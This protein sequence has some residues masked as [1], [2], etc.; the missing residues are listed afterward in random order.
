MVVGDG[1]DPED[2]RVP[3]WHFEW[4]VLALFHAAVMSHCLRHIFSH[5]KLCC[6]TILS[7]FHWVCVKEIVLVA[8]IGPPHQPCTPSRM[9]PFS[10]APG[11]E[12]GLPEGS[13]S[14]RFRSPR[15][16]SHGPSTSG[17]TGSNGATGGSA[18]GCGRGADA[19]E[20]AA[21]PAPTP[22]VLEKEE[23]DSYVSGGKLLEWH[24]DL[25]K[26]PLVTHRTGHTPEDVR[27]VIK[28]GELQGVDS[29][30]L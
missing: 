12:L 8:R 25:F 17:S 23:F 1:S 11:D 22:V 20:A 19:S 7:I 30:N 26:H 27:S 4:R 15:T 9:T 28:E 24:A 6:D 18:G 5:H 13:L 10:F 3:G 16:P 29:S 14:L 2:D 21:N